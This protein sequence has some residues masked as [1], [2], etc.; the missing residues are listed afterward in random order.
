MGNIVHRKKAKKLAVKYTKEEPHGQK[1]DAQG[2]IQLEK[3]EEKPIRI[4]T[5][6]QKKIIKNTVD[7]LS[8]IP[9]LKDATIDGILEGPTYRYG[10]YTLTYRDNTFVRGITNRTV[11]ST[12]QLVNKA[13]S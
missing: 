4:L 5:K 11:R 9:K 12:T 13:F 7:I 2:T 1:I 3:I 6:G 8:C 10:D